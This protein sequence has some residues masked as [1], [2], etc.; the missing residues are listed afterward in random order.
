MIL[1][2]L[3]MIKIKLNY[4][5][6][7]A[8]LMGSALLTLVACGGG[9]NLAERH[10]EGVWLGSLVT[11]QG[12]CPTEHLSALRIQK[13]VILFSPGNGAIILRGNYNSKLH[14]RHFTARLDK[15]DMDH[16]PYVLLFDGKPKENT[17]IGTYGNPDC[18]AH[19]TLYPPRHYG[20]SEAI[21]P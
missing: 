6:I 7:K 12:S 4:S 1:L 17:I 11:D 20:L 18:R 5:K 14:P 21:A 2:E 15:V 10:P 3:S 19:I 13:K 8:T 16:K 9:N